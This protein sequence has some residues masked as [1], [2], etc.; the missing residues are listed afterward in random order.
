MDVGALL[1]CEAIQLQ[2]KAKLAKSSSCIGSDV[3][4]WQPSDIQTIGVIIGSFFAQ[5][6]YNNATN[7]VEMNY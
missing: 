6:D 2:G 1:T 5:F 7:F 4:N 3:S